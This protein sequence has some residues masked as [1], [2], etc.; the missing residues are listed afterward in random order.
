MCAAFHSALDAYDKLVTA[1]DG[2]DESK[3]FEGIYG[4]RSHLVSGPLRWLWSVE[5][6]CGSWRQ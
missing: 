1:T 5:T 6:E 2:E 3:A 4:G